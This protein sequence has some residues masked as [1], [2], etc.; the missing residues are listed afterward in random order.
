MTTLLHREE[1]ESTRNNEDF[2]TEPQKGGKAD[3]ASD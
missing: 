3:N 2:V 1:R